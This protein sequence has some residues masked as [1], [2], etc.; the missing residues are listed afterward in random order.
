MND[1]FTQFWGAGT[2]FGM[3]TAII[4]TVLLF[5]ISL[6]LY[7]F[8]AFGNYVKAV[9]G[10]KT[11][12]LF[13][14]IKVDNI[15]IKVFVISGF[16]SAVAGLLMTSRLKSGRPEVGSGMEL[17]AVAAVILGGT[18]LSGGRGSIFNTLIG[19]LIMGV[20]VNGLIILG[21]QSNVQ[22][23]I[24]GVIIIAAVSLSEKQ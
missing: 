18:P 15:I 8:S 16:F 22:Q 23:I 4:W 21:I 2:F 11:A 24:K 7:R 1:T 14:G 6:F 10:N 5:L 17:D 9:G 19:S 3:S 13:S 12:S 20:I